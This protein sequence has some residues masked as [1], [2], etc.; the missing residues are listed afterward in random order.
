M[1]EVAVEPAQRAHRDAIA[2]M[3]QLY[4]HD[5]SEQWFDQ[6]RG[7]LNE[8]G[9][10][11]PYPYLDAYWEED[12]CLPFLIR[13]N[14]KLAGFALINCDW[15]SGQSADH[16]MAEFFVVR[17]YRRAGVGAAAAAHLFKTLPGVWEVAVA[18]RNTRA[19]SF[20]VRVMAPFSPTRLEGDGDHWSGPIFRF[21]SGAG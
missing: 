20:W 4:I 21:R 3:L 8:D 12:G 6:A 10:F 16:S 18:E 14:G 1:T 11:D 9:M 7:E 17:K 2:A 15:H 5:F 13:A 19:L